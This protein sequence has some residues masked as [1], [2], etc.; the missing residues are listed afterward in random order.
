MTKSH[1]IDDKIKEY[2][3]FIK[4][5]LPALPPEEFSREYSRIVASEKPH[6][7]LGVAQTASYEQATDAYQRLVQIL[8]PDRLDPYW[9]SLANSVLDRLTFSREYFRVKASEKPHEVLGIP[10]TARYEQARKA[11]RRSVKILHP[12]RLN[13]PSWALLANWAFDKLTKAYGHYQ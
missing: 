6:E 8:R 3:D 10:Q 11:Y 13:D 5:P 12:D 4:I 7:V 2:K 1:C 9:A